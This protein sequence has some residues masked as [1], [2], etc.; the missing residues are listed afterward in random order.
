MSSSDIPIVQLLGITKRFSPEV[1]AND[2][3]S[4]DIQEGEIHALLGENGAGKSTLMQILY[5]IF[6]RDSGDIL[7]DGKPVAM[8]SPAEAIGHGIGMI[9]QEFMLVQ[10]FSVTENVLMGVSSAGNE[11]AYDPKAVSARLKAL[12]AEFGLDVDP[13]SRI[14]HLPVGV[15]QRVEILKLLYREARVLIL[16]EPTAVLTPQE[17]DRLF[18][19]LRALRESGKSIVIVTHKLREILDVSDRVTVLRDGRTVATVSTALT[20]GPE[21]ARLMVGR[22]IVLR[23]DKSAEN[24]GRRLLQVDDLEVEDH[25]GNGRLKGV[26]LEV[27][28]G[29][30]LGVAGVD[31]NGQSELMEALFGMRPVAGG[32]VL[33]DGTEITHWTPVQRRAARLAYIPADRR[34][35][36]S[37]SELSIA[38]NGILGAQRSFGRFGGWWLNRRT[39]AEHARDL[40]TRFGVRT[41]HPGY[42]AGKLSGGNLQKV[43]LGR[44]VMRNPTVLL[45][46][47]PTRGLDIGA[48]ETVW[49]ELLAQRAARKA[50]LLVSAELEEILN[51]ADRIAVLYD[52]RI[53]GVVKLAETDVETLG[54]MMAGTPLIE[55]R[56]RLR[57]PAGEGAHGPH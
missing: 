29:E 20:N 52:G 36:G 15:Q 8:A 26:S 19:V 38:D 11:S 55:L 53:M 23:S 37:L 30:I 17:V 56:R 57:H 12:A 41:P 50:I 45:V 31:G 3:V 44:E 9:H 54:L 2:H 18:S 40:I 14:E 22:D 47:Q 13:E 49:Q 51:L 21:L 34:L 16:D 27:N 7:I 10:P 28:E 5:G 39:V 32:R 24:P 33:L 43:V 6:H 35:V 4:L 25:A 48:V 46:E 1:L 42:A